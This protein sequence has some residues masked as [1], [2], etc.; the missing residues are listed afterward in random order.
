MINVI[1]KGLCANMSARLIRDTDAQ[2]SGVSRTALSTLASNLFPLLTRT[3][4][5]QSQASLHTCLN[6]RWDERASTNFELP[7]TDLLYI[8]EY[9]R[10]GAVFNR[11]DVKCSTFP[12]IR[13]V[14]SELGI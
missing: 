7:H 10:S 4:D 14:A 2:K 3:L 9:S 11:H 6:P 1:L 12:S 13:T 5:G 8:A